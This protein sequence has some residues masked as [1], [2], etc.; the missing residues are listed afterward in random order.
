MRSALY[1]TQILIV[2]FVV[3]EKIDKVRFDIPVN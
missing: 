3:T 1:V 2:P